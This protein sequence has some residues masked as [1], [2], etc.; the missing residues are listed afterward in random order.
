[1]TTAHNLA[2]RTSSRSSNGEKCVE[3]APTTDGVVIRHSK[4]PEAGTIEFSRL[5]W[6]AFI[7]EARGNLSTSNGTAEINRSGTDTIVK[8]LTSPVQ[9]HFDAAEWTAF[10]A[11]ASDGEFSFLTDHTTTVR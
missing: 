5:A 2:W 7:E 3:V 8:S 1:M 11:G 4:H 9:L 6:Q 10:V